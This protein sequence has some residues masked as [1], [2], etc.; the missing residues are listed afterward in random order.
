MYVAPILQFKKLFEVQDLYAELSICDEIT[1]TWYCWHKHIYSSCCSNFWKGQNP[2]LLLNPCTWFYLQ[3]LKLFFKNRDSVD[4]E[5]STC[6][7]FW[8]GWN[9]PYL[10][11]NYLQIW[12]MHQKCNQHSTFFWFCLLWLEI[13]TEIIWYSHKL[14]SHQHSEFPK[15]SD[16]LPK[17]GKSH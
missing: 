16:G 15:S 10:L 13:T 6:S 14:T 4:T 1:T 5:S 11:L 17:H 7:N 12:K 2:Y 9:P 8:R 3:I